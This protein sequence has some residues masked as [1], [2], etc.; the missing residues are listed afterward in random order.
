MAGTSPAMTLESVEPCSLTLDVMAG[1]IPAI[2]EF[3]QERRKLSLPPPCYRNIFTMA[4][5][6][7]RQAATLMFTVIRKDFRIA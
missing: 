3:K 7:K 1:F 2:H 6:A 5:I 4:A